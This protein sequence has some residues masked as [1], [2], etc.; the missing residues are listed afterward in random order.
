MLNN[1]LNL[2]ITSF[3][4]LLSSPSF[5]AMAKKSIREAIQFQSDSESFMSSFDLE[6]KQLVP[7]ESVSAISA[8]CESENPSDTTKGKHGPNLDPSL[9]FT[10][11]ACSSDARFLSKSKPSRCRSPTRVPFNT[12]SI[13]PSNSYAH[14][15]GAQT[16]EELCFS[17]LDTPLKHFSA[18][19]FSSM[20]D[21]TLDFD[22]NENDDG[23]FRTSDSVS[24][25][26]SLLA[27][28]RAPELTNLQKGIGLGITG[29]TKNDMSGP[30]DG[31]GLVA[32]NRWSAIS[33]LDQTEIVSDMQPLLPY[34][35]STSSDFF[36]SFDQAGELTNTFFQEALF[37]FTQDPLHD[38]SLAT[39]PE[40]RS[41]YERDED[42]ISPS[43]SLILE[44]GG[45]VGYQSELQ[46]NRASNSEAK[47]P[48]KTTRRHFSSSTISS[49]LKRM[50]T[51]ARFGVSRTRSATWPDHS[52]N[53]HLGRPRAWR[54]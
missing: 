9:Q 47:T 21:M 7:I 17:P 12:P 23:D 20:A 33:R 14:L 36:V 28:P 27:I 41:W 39:I 45:S 19:R 3:S 52:C 38:H 34:S 54:A 31:L 6:N 15:L 13:T 25:D 51:S 4:Q 46:S 37:T 44:E 11:T 43:A 29:L 32:I 24:T 48:L 53:Q 26:S 18:S 30:F 10:F 35:R 16:Q 42:W 49:E 50:T 5:T 1:F 2:F 22:D 40:C 8:G